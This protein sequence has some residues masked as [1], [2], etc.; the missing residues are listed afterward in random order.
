MTPS[1]A[2]RWY[3]AL[4]ESENRLHQAI[5]ASESPHGTGYDVFWSDEFPKFYGGNGLF[6]RKS[7]PERTLADWI[8]LFRSHFSASRFEHILLCFEEGKITPELCSEAESAGFKVSTDLG[9]VAATETIAVASKLESC[10]LLETHEHFESLRALQISEDEGA[11][12]F[13]SVEAFDGLFAK[14]LALTERVSINWLAL[15]HPEVPGRLG[16]GLG[17]FDVPNL[18][19]LQDVIT[20]PDSRRRGFASRLIRETALRA[21]AR[22]VQAI[23]LIAEGATD[24]ERLYTTLGFHTINREISLMRY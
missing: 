23:G 9:M 18:C 7:A 6:V 10:Y 19:R 22:G 24:A 14:L 2:V 3:K 15:P 13:T 5:G 1:Q 8:E 21:R 17:Y 20:A 4:Q 16:A 11:D 12:W